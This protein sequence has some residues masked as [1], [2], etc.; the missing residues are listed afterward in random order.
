MYNPTTPD[1]ISNYN[2]GGLGYEISNI[3]TKI[4]DLYNNINNKAKALYDGTV[5][6][7]GTIYQFPYVISE[8]IVHVF[9]NGNSEICLQGNITR[10]FY[11]WFSGSVK[12]LRM[13]G[14]PTTS[15][16][17]S[18]G[19][20]AVVAFSEI[21]NSI[22]LNSAYIGNTNVRDSTITCVSFR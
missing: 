18:N 1:D 20:T 3:N 19:Y 9:I 11:S 6:Q 5:I 16:N 7:G 21:S 14:Y 22:S 13:V 4:N 15:L 8:A 12:A 17:N 2:I 10:D